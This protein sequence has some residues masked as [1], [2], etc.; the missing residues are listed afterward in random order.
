MNRNKIF[1]FVEKRAKKIKKI[2]YG[3]E[4]KI[5]KMMIKRRLDNPRLQLS[6]AN[7]FI[8]LGKEK[9]N[10]INEK[11]FDSVLN[12]MEK[13]LANNYAVNFTKKELSALSLKSSIIL[14]DTNLIL[15]KYRIGVKRLLLQNMGKGLS[16]GQVVQGLK[17]LYPSFSQHCYTVA[18][19]GLQR[20][21]KDGNFTKTSQLFKK[22][23]YLGPDDNVTR[24]FCADHVGR[25]FEKK[26]AEQ[27]QAK[28]MGLFNCR[29]SLEPVDGKLIKDE[30]SKYTDDEMLQSAKYYTQ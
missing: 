2:A 14:D 21:Y 25:V 16:M 20:I 28:I 6:I 12:S 8:E 15:S 23:K 30:K 17:T 10:Y 3:I 4:T 24:A 5:S 18:N 19:T 29:H 1:N 26:E 27:L 7:N 9:I 13:N 22:F 11:S